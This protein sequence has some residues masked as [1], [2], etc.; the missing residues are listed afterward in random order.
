MRFLAPILFLL[1]SPAWAT[2]TLVQHT[3]NVACTGGSCTVTVSSTGAG[4]LGVINTATTN[5]VTIS[6]ISG[7]TLC[8][9]NCQNFDGAGSAGAIDAAYDLVLAGGLTSIPVTFSNTVGGGIVEFTEWAYTAGPISFDTSADVLRSVAAS[10][11]TGPAFTLSGTHDLVIQFCNSS[12]NLTAVSSPYNN[13][14]S[15]DLGTCT[16]WNF[17]TALNTAANWT[18]VSNYH[19]AFGVIAFKETAVLTVT[20]RALQF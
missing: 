10:P 6:S 11:Q 12:A 17:N 16:A 3:S 7:F 15:P 2:W 20:R 1:T 5:N 19:G 13:S 4:H 14:P 18:G 9:V 8:G